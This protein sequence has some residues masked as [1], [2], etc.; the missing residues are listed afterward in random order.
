MNA[1]ETIAVYDVRS[2][3]DIAVLRLAAD[4]IDARISDDSEGGLNPGFYARY[5]VRV[6]VRADDV[7]DAYV[8]LGIERVSVPAQ[9]AD[10]MFKHAGW[11]YPHEAC[12]LVGVDDAGVP[13]LVMCLSNVDAA[14]DRF[15]IAPDE[16]F[17]A[18][19]LAER[20]GLTVGAVFHSHPTSDAYPSQTDVDGGGDPDWLH[21][22]V[23]PVSGPKPLL[24]CFRIRDGF[25]SEVKVTV[26]Q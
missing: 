13:V 16:Y 12:G 20:R 3:A 19:R 26:E 9:V 23:G 7:D 21:F 22:I 25:V 10:A 6:I 14:S 17:G 11:A 1:D 18:N 5:G 8:S 24:R 15:T 4:G 2:D